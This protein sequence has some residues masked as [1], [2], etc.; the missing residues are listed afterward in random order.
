MCSLV[1][2]QKIA[3]GGVAIIDKIKRLIKKI[4]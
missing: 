3:I 1:E 2:T 4:K